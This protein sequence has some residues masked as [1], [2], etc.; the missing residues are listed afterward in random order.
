MTNNAPNQ[1]IT[2]ATTDIVEIDGMPV[3][4]PVKVILRLSLRPTVVIESDDLPNSVMQGKNF[5]IS[6]R[7]NARVEV[8]VKSLRIS[9]KIGGSLIPVHQPVDVVDKGLPI[10]KVDFGIINFPELYGNQSHWISD[11]KTAKVIP[12]VKLN[13]SNWC[14]ELT[15]VSNISEI[16]KTLKQDGGFSLTYRGTITRSDGVGFSAK[17][18]VALLEA[19]RIFLSFARGSLCSL[20]LIEGLQEDGQQT[21]LRWG[22]HHV[23]PWGAKHSWFRQFNGADILSALFPRFW[24]L[25]GTGGKHTQVIPRAID[26]YLQSNVSPPYVGIILTIAALE[27]LS[28]KVL[29]RTKNKGERT[30]EFIQEALKKLKVPLSIPNSSVELRNVKVWAHGPHAVVAIRDGLVHPTQKLGAVSNYVHYEAWNLGQWYIEMIL[31]RMLDY[32]GS[33]VNRLAS[34]N[35]PEQHIQTVP[36]A[37]KGC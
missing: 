22:V 5:V 17:D 9:T 12:G 8:M 20:S 18:V 26:W 16:K 3:N 29:G 28:D 35:E 1:P 21:W 24:N 10:S 34:W 2:L 13:A 36:W 7:N 30:G 14:I 27:L 15:G 32:Q 23:E 33:Y 37:K 25:L 31:L 6:L 4:V 19:L 11:G